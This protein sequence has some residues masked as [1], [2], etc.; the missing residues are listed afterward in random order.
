MPAVIGHEIF[1]LESQGPCNRRDLAE[2]EVIGIGEATTQC[3]VCDARRD[4][5]SSDAPPLNLERDVD[6]LSDIDA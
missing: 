2:S 3:L 4:G 6:T 5:Q 1:K